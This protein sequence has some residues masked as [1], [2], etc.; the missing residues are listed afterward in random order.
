MVRAAGDRGRHSAPTG[1]WS[2]CRCGHDRT[3][4]EH[5]RRG[6]DCSVAGCLCTRFRRR[7]LGR[8]ETSGTDAGPTGQVV[9]WRGP[10]R[11]SRRRASR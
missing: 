10:R 9:P 6:T 5:Y 1:W 2:L 8:T 4:H 3:A 11:A 7:V